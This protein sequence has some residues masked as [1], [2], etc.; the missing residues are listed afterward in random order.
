MQRWGLMRKY[1]FV[2]GGV[3]SDSGKTTLSASIGM[4]LSNRG[5]DV[6]NKKLSPYLNMEVGALDSASFG[7]TFV[8]AEGSEADL[9]LGVYERFTGRKT[10]KLCFSTAGNIYWSV[11]NKE[12]MG[13]FPGEAV[14]V[15]KHF[16]DEVREFVVMGDADIVV[17]EIG[18]TLGDV[19]TVQL[20]DA[21]S[22]A[23]DAF[24]T[25]NVMYVHVENIPSLVASEEEKL[26]A[27]NRSTSEL[28]KRGIHPDCVV[29]RTEKPMDSSLQN[30]ISI[31]CNVNKDCVVEWEMKE[32][33]YEAPLV[34]EKNGISKAILRRLSLRDF[35]PKLD[36]WKDFVLKAQKA[37]KE[38]RIA[39]VGKNTSLQ[40][41]YQSVK[42]SVE[43]AA[44]K[45][46]MVVVL[47]WVNSNELNE[48]N[49]QLLLENADGIIV[50]D[51]KGR[52]GTEGMMLASKYARENDVPFIAIG[53]GMHMSVVSIAKDELGLKGAQ[54][55][56]NGETPYPVVVDC[57]MRSGEEKIK[58]LRGTK[59]FSAYGRELFYE[60]CRHKY[61]VS[62][63]YR[64]KLSEAGMYFTGVSAENEFCEIVEMPALRYYIGVQFNPEF[65]STPER[66]H[67]LFDSFIKAVK[68]E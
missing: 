1:I 29:C 42:E 60:R 63:A 66:V 58:I 6:M 32:G 53:Q 28:I 16:A 57:D 24:G 36:A 50:P 8:T 19:E 51:G 22:K 48:K 30:K 62:G 14:T 5:F 59:T 26:V 49:A 55:T 17:T 11:I 61:I 35:K 54:S 47:D 65:T 52:K 37:D 13:S 67:P 43:C 56:E 33:L 2:T 20:I 25:E 3:V 39:I 34:L 12:R 64:E 27:L 41:A 10:N 18:G 46:E 15:S 40:A 31:F 44:Y 7:E 23:K 9:S 38:I 68:G 4:L 45:N 21:I